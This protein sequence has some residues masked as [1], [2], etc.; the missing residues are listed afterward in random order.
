M[1]VEKINEANVVIK[2]EADNKEIDAK[3]EKVA[4]K[5][6]KQVKVDGFRKGKVP[7]AVVKKMYAEAIE[8]K[9][10]MN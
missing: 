9:Q 4:K 10:L 5:F 6:A 8:K 1:A 7:V 3:K 2:I